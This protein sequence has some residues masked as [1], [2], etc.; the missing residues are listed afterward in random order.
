MNGEYTAP[1]ACEWCANL[2]AKPCVVIERLERRIAQLERM[3]HV[4]D[5]GKKVVFLDRIQR[6]LDGAE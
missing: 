4:D 2:D 5:K 1:C 3:A 6:A